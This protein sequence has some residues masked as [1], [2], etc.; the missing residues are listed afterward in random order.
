MV[1]LM[2]YYYNRVEEPLPSVKNIKEHILYV[3]DVEK[4]LITC[5]KKDVHLVDFLMLELGD[6]NISYYF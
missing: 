1:K 2:K 5:K 6:V 4:I 3:E